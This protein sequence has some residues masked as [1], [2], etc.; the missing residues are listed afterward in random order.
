[1]SQTI[2]QGELLIINK[3]GL[4]ARAAA[5]LINTANQYESTVRIGFPDRMVD[6][7]NIMS[8]MM[9]AAGQ[10]TLLQAQIEGHDAVQ[11]Y[12]ALQDLFARRF[13]EEE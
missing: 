2:V 3:R 12:Q 5:K 7:K 10:D 6:G 8:V 4:H 9:L 1:M 11:A 13:D